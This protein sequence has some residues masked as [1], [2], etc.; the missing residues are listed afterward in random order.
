MAAECQ[1]ERGNEFRGAVAVPESYRIDEFETLGKRQPRLPEQ[2]GSSR[3]SR[4]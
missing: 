3:A 2:A 4:V 1:T